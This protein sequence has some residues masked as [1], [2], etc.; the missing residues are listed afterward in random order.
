MALLSLIESAYKV[1]WSIE[2]LEKLTAR[3]PKRGEDK[4]SLPSVVVRGER[5]IES[6]DLDAY[7]IYLA[8]PWPKASTAK[9][10]HIP[11]AI[12]TDVKGECH[13]ACAICGLQESGE[14]AHIEAVATTENNSPDNLLLLCPKWGLHLA[15]VDPENAQFLTSRQ[16]RPVCSRSRLGG[17]IRAR[18]GGGGGGRVRPAL[19]SSL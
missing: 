4:K 6:D 1:G 2:L 5:M 15:A 8:Q 3:G 16:G 18:T 17:S 7:V 9:R 10:P 13:L 11:V 19:T 14:L 12:K